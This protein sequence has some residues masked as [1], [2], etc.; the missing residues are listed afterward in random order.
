MA[1]CRHT[2]LMGSHSLAQ[3]F[4]LCKH[5]DSETLADV[6]LLQA[7]VRRQQLEIEKLWQVADHLA[8]SHSSF[9]QDYTT[10]VDS[11]RLHATLPQLAP[12]VAPAGGS[13]GRIDALLC[14]TKGAAL[15]LMALAG[16]PAS[17]ALAAASRNCAKGLGGHLLKAKAE[18]SDSMR[19]VV[20]PTPLDYVLDACRPSH[21][22]SKASCSTLSSGCLAPPWAALSP[23]QGGRDAAPSTASGESTAE[24]P[25]SSGSSLSEA[26]EG[27]S[28]TQISE[29][30]PCVPASLRPRGRG[31]ALSATS[32]GSS[33]DEALPPAPPPLAG[34]TWADGITPLLAEMWWSGGSREL[35]SPLGSDEARVFR[36]C[37]RAFS[38]SARAAQRCRPTAPAG[39]VA[40]FPARSPSFAERAEFYKLDDGG[41]NFVPCPVASVT[42]GAAVPSSEAPQHDGA[43]VREVLGGRKNAGLIAAGTWGFEGARSPGAPGTSDDA[44]AKASATAAEDCQGG[45]TLP[46]LARRPAA[47]EGKEAAAT[48][49]ATAATAAAG[50][51][52]SD[53]TAAPSPV[54]W[55]AVAEASVESA[56]PGAAQAEPPAPQHDGAAVW[57]VVGG[58]RNAGLIVRKGK[59][60]GAPV[61]GYAERGVCRLGAGA[62]LLEVHLEDG[63]LEFLKLSGEGPRSGWINTHALGRPLL[64]RHVLGCPVVFE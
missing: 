1:Q 50:K 9:L 43:A 3:T 55:P 51:A 21:P 29:T 8:Q 64:K 45:A 2:A 54:P 61:V 40:L 6:Y 27:D 24:E 11:L 47:S 59:D 10:L 33:E 62:R 15:G 30:L 42:A 60:L 58:R 49:T 48:A 63:R 46:V 41:W 44:G 13:A 18:V 31:A 20:A 56:P 26:S 25:P 57:E 35:W 52:I 16:V 7:I 12:P 38:E 23:R 22:R 4:D 14:G 28:V 34:Q 36:A 17:G 19:R 32:D 53:S 39:D 5:S 37:A